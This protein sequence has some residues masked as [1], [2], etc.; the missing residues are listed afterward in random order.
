MNGNTD[1][2]DDAINVF[3]AEAEADI[4]TSI[5]E[6]YPLPLSSFSGFSGSQGEKIISSVARR[7]SAGLLLKSLNPGSE[8]VQVNYED[9]KKDLAAIRKGEKLLVESSEAQVSGTSASGYVPTYYSNKV[10]PTFTS[11]MVL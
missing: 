7:L 1:I 2:T 9:A 3:I 6:R 8:Y 11:D 10:S 5:S 4:D